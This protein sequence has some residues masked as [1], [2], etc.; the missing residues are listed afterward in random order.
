ML[1]QAQRNSLSNEVISSYLKNHHNIDITKYSPEIQKKFVEEVSMLFAEFKDFDTNMITSLRSIRE[2]MSFW[3]EEWKKDDYYRNMI[4][5][6]ALQSRIIAIKLAIDTITWEKIKIWNKEYN[7]ADYEE[8]KTKTTK[9]DQN[10]WLN[11]FSK[12]ENSPILTNYWKIAS[13]FSNELKDKIVNPQPSWNLSYDEII[14]T[15]PKAWNKWDFEKLTKVTLKNGQTINLV[16]LSEEYIKTYKNFEN[17]NQIFEKWNKQISTSQKW[18]WFSDPKVYWMDYDKIKD[19]YKDKFEELNLENMWMAD[20]VIMM[21]V[22]FSIIPVVWNSV[23]WYDDGKQALAWVNFDGSMHGIWENVFMY[24]ISWL[25]L[26]IVWWWFAKLAKWPKLAKAMMTIWKIIEKLSK[27]P[28]MLKDLAKN[29]KVMKMLEAMKWVVPN[30]DNLL[31]KIRK[32]KTLWENANTS[33][34]S[35]KD[36]F[37]AGKQVLKWKT[38]KIPDNLYKSHFSTEIPES[39]RAQNPM[40]WIDTSWEIHYNKTFLEEKFGIKITTENGKTLFDGK[41]LKD[42]KKVHE[43]LDFLK[44]LKAHEVT[45][46]ILEARGI[47]E[48]KVWD[49]IYSQEDICSIVDGSM[50]LEIRE[51]EA[52]EK[53]LKEKLWDDF[54]LLKNWELD[55]D[56]LRRYDTKM[57]AKWLD[58][59]RE[60]EA[61]MRWLSNKIDWQINMASEELKQE[62]FSAIKDKNFSKV[63]EIIVESWF[64]F[65]EDILLRLINIPWIKGRSFILLVANNIEKFQWNYKEL[66]TALI[67]FWETDYIFRHLSK[68][69]W[70][71]NEIIFICIKLWVDMKDNFL[72]ILKNLDRLNKIGLDSKLYSFLNKLKWRESDIETL[73]RYS[74]LFIIN[75]WDKIFNYFLQ[76]KQKSLIPFMQKLLLT[77]DLWFE[78][79]FKFITN[80]TKID[81][82]QWMEIWPAK[83]QLSSNLEKLLSITENPQKDKIL[84]E[85]NRYLSTIKTFDEKA[86]TWLSKYFEKPIID[87]FDI[88]FDRKLK[89]KII[90]ELWMSSRNFD[91]AKLMENNEFIE[92][93][94]MYHK[95]TI[96]KQQFKSILESFVN[97][98]DVRT[99]LN[100]PKNNDWLDMMRQKWVKIETFLQENKQTIQIAGDVKKVDKL[101]DAEH[102]LTVANNKLKLIWIQETFADTWK[103]IHYF[104][105]D[106]K[107]NKEVIF[108]KSWLQKQEFDSLYADIELQIKSMKEVLKSS[109]ARE[110][111][112]ITIHRETDPMKVLMMWNLVDGSCLSFYSTVWNFWS[113]ATNALDINKSV[114]YISDQN[115]NIIWRVLT[116][117]DDNWKLV[118]FPM[119]KKWNIE[120]DLDTYFNDYIKDL[121]YNSTLWLNGKVDEVTLLA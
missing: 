92:I 100:N 80:L 34:V 74:E 98:R 106:F 114:F 11:I 76:N 53:V 84:Q 68:F 91:L 27:S 7:K 95:A 15:L 117:I 24:L 60:S 78:T 94:K 22:L 29:E 32:A 109:K 20:L 23:W 67:E 14:R 49:K 103:M 55:A 112:S 35:D 97:W 38:E 3:M 71:G 45:H 17:K 39:L 75:D 88:V 26:T 48:I 56:F 62:I 90:N 96:N 13:A 79:N 1:S 46:R 64:L 107:K 70:Y 41:S 21:R 19:V 31:A 43:I 8:L 119:Y 69:N 9:L 99:V 113:T 40:A 120:I 111:S 2:W 110:I 77:I 89:L 104:D 51:L 83:T 36:K 10:H 101:Q 102:F 25:Q 59:S 61:A 12:L 33:V 44:E 28:E 6:N 4:I 54:R 30:I 86:I 16:E 42:H 58:V 50:K 5:W 72:D 85:F 108:E 118:R 52:L 73:L 115:G 105:S 63:K 47:T 121:T 65:D 82:I 116:A 93:F 57:V 37:K 81:W 18:F 87:Y 66:I